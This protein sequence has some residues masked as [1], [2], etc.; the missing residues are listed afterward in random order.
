MFDLFGVRRLG[1]QSAVKKNSSILLGVW[2][3][4]LATFELAPKVGCGASPIRAFWC[5]RE[6]PRRLDNGNPSE[7]PNMTGWNLIWNW[8]LRMNSDILR[9][10]ECSL[11][12]FDFC[13]QMS[14]CLMRIADILNW[15]GLSHELFTDAPD[16][17]GSPCFSD[18][19]FKWRG[20]ALKPLGIL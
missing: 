5:R 2:K 17:H 1:P 8:S 6:S 19:M 20:L 10:V 18:C 9:P 11:S 16:S 13:E 3:T 4:E 15:K 7:V 14:F 12:C